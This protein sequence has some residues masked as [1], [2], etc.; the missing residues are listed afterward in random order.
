MNRSAVSQSP[1]EKYTREEMET[2]FSRSQR[3]SILLLIVMISMIAL[4]IYGLIQKDFLLDGGSWSLWCYIVPALIIWKRVTLVRH[5]FAWNSVPL[6]AADQELFGTIDKQHFTSMVTELLEPLKQ[7]K[8]EV[9]NVYINIDTELNAYA[10]NSLMFNFIGKLNA[11]YITSGLIKHL[12]LVEIR[13]IMAHEIAH[14]EKY[15]SLLSRVNLIDTLF[16]ALPPVYLYSI[17]F[18]QPQ[19]LLGTLFCLFFIY[20]IYSVLNFILS[21]FSNYNDR[22]L[23][24]LSDCYAAERYGKLNMINALLALGKSSELLEKIIRHV[25]HKLKEDPQLPLTSLLDISLFMYTNLNEKND[26]KKRKLKLRIDALWKASEINAMRSEAALSRAE[27]EQRKE[28]LKQIEKEL[29]QTFSMHDW[30]RFD[31]HIQD[32]KIDVDEYSGFIEELRSNPDRQ[33]FATMDDNQEQTM[34]STHPSFTK[35]ILFIADNLP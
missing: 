25:I 31:T 8:R 9:P 33:L 20:F 10:V 28:A 30:T 29:V 16:L 32:R 35:R 2:L 23:E 18:D 6:S 13:A 14:F 5:I 17:V 19:S 7:K 22:I 21:L 26:A 34:I 24:H 1:L 11:I 12:S 4:S 15:S 3:H 27:Q